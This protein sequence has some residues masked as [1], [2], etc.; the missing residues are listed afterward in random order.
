MYTLIIAEKPSVAQSI[1]AVVGSRKRENGYLSGLRYLVSWCIGNLVELAPPHAYNE[2]YKQWRAEDLPI[3]PDEWRYE[4]HKETEKQLNILKRLMNMTEVDHII[5]ATDAGR[6]GELIFRLVYA[7]CHCSKP[8]KRLWISSMEEGAIQEGM[9]H[10][11]DDSDFDH[12]YEAAL[13][14]QKA[15]WLVGM[16][17]SRLFSLLYGTT[18]QVGRVLTPTLALITHREEAIASFQPEPFY[19]VLLRCGFDAFSERMTDKAEAETIQKACHMQSAVVKAVDLKR[20]SEKPPKLYDLTSLQRDANRL[21]GYTAQQT[22]DYAQSLYEKKL[23]TYPRTDSRYLTSEQRDTLPG[24]VSSLAAL[25]NCMVYREMVCHAEQ[26]VDDSQVSDHH[27]MIPTQSLMS[28]KWEE[29]P[30]GEKD[31]LVMIVTRLLC[32]VA[33]PYEYEETIVTVT[34][35][36]YTFT[37]K[38]RNQV[39]PGWKDIDAAFR[40]FLGNRTVQE[41][42]EPFVRL[43]A[44]TVGEERKPCIAQ[45]NEGTT[46]QPRR[47]TEET[48]LAAMEHAGQEDMPDDAE[49]KGL[50]TPATRAGILEKLIQGKLVERTGSGK[51]KYLVPTEKG[52]A[53][54]E[55]VPETIQSPVMTAEWE[56]RLKKIEHGQA[57]PDG[58]ISD[59]TEMLRD[60][61]RKAEPVPGAAELF[62]TNKKQVGTC[63]HCG[64]PVSETPKG[65]FCENHTCRFGIWKDNKFFVS[66][67]KKITASLVTALLK[68]RSLFMKNLYSEKTGKTYDATISLETD[69]AGNAKFQITF[70]AK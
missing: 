29:L 56:Q 43:P 65:F 2:S 51:V 21:L 60:L 64:A 18:L 58:F 5:C 28:V 23:I 41:P 16:N 9:E 66:K 7:Y 13:C 39:N 35:A 34:C 25:F 17:A 12:L 46:T 11:R 30:T 47:Y 59:I 8:V 53:L 40:G 15:D 55:I 37:G 38:G 42:A 22:L 32:A 31:I 20:R 63:P 54:A 26:V 36:G 49:R 33:D 45:L 69:D 67:G 70:P 3:V 48:L 62:P 14:R 10:L 24:F 68:E 6:E 1:A 27:A 61:I 4:A 50:G 52:R 19:K 57:D 44:L